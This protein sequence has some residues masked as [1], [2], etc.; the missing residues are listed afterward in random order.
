MPIPSWY[1][2]RLPVGRPQASIGY[3]PGTIYHP[4]PKL[5]TSRNS[6]DGSQGVTIYWII[7]LLNNIIVAYSIRMSIYLLIRLRILLTIRVKL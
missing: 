4:L 5:V 1:I 2:V 7:Y 6:R 3:S